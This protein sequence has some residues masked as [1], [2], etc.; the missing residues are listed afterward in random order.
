MTKS[1]FIKNYGR[2]IAMFVYIVVLFVNSYGFNLSYNQYLIDYFDSLHDFIQVR[3]KVLFLNLFFFSST[4]IL[5]MIFTF[6]YYRYKKRVFLTAFFPFI[7]INHFFFNSSVVDL[8]EKGDNFS[9]NTNSGIIWIL[10]LPMNIIAVL[11]I[12]YFFDYIKNRGN[13]REA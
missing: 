5:F 7:L 8:I 1:F 13:K 4:T 6:A 11:V 12:G 9:Y 10:V 2:I 3:N